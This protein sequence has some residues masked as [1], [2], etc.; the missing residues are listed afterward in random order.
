MKARPKITHESGPYGY[1]NGVPDNVEPR[2]QGG[3]YYVQHRSDGRIR[4]VYSN[5]GRKQIGRWFPPDEKV[6]PCTN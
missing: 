5:A 2:I 1:H 3:I 6:L 4:R